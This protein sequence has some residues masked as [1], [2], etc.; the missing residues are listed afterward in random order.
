MN[1]LV[2]GGAGFM[3]SH[4]VDLLIEQRHKVTVVDNLA[5]GKMSNVPKKAEFRFGDITKK[6]ITNS[7]MLNRNNERIEVIF[8]LAAHAAEGQSIFNPIFTTN[9]NYIGSLNVLESWLEYGDPKFFVFT[10]S[11]AVY[12]TQKDMP[13]KEDQ[14]PH[15]ED[16]YGITKYAFEMILPIYAKLYGFNYVI[17]RPHN[18][19]GPRQ[20]L[21]DPYRNVVGIFINRILHGDPPIIYGDGEQKRAFT[22]INDCTPYIVKAMKS[23]RAFGEVI[24]I[25]SQEVVTVN[26]LAQLILAEMESD[27]QPIHEE[28]RPQEVKLAYCSNNKAARILGHKTKTTLEEGI[29]KTVEW[30]KKVGKQTFNYWTK[31]FE[32]DK[33]VPSTWKE[34]KL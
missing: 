14:T 16:P 18:V 11:M 32:L 8:H 17:I 19:Y 15:P 6:T 10:S 25:G 2:T 9:V 13:M 26:H 1:I 12:G 33:G 23:A 27:L 4:L 22:Y 31:D 7:I 5:T 21:R 24:N 20:S 3:G 29:T 28:E 34:K 30:A